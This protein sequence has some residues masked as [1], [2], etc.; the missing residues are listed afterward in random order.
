MTNYPQTYWKQSLQYLKL[1]Y[2]DKG[3]ILHFS[4]WG[5]TQ[6][7]STCYNDSS[8]SLKTPS[9]TCAILL[10]KSMYT[11]NMLIVSATILPRHM[12]TVFNNYDC[13]LHAGVGWGVKAPYI[14][15][16]KKTLIKDRR[17]HLICRQQAHCRASGIGW[18]FCPLTMGKIQLS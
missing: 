10:C 1:A 5:F 15:V 6:A 13:A 11:L 9:F 16:S 3:V 17:N 14:H 4:K 8:V 2:V 7:T 12:C 18:Y